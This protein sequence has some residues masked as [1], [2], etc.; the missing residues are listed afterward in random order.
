MRAT[1]MSR[2]NTTGM[3]VTDGRP[4]LVTFTRRVCS[5]SAATPAASASCSWLTRN[6]FAMMAMDAM[7]PRTPIGY[8]SE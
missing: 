6:T 2:P 1:M 4:A 3:S 5:G 7:T 8:A